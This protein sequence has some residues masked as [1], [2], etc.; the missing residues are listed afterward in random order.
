MRWVLASL[1]L[2]ALGIGMGAVWARSRALRGALDAGALQRALTADVWWGIAALLWL[3]TGLWR[4]FA[5]TEKPPS[6][7]MTNSW[8]FAKMALFVLIVLLEIWPA[9]TFAR[10]R[11]A[12][13]RGDMPDTRSAGALATVSVFQAALVV[14]MVGAATAVARGY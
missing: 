2:I 5:G 7:Y 9:V 12:R 3:S 13:S 11:A 8:F 4:L 14:A 1:H 6:Y 10:W